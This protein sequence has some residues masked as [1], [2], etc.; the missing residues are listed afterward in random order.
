[1]LGLKA[2]TPGLEALFILVFADIVTFTEK[3]ARL[4]FPQFHEPCD[5]TSFEDGETDPEKAVFPRSH[6]T[7]RHSGNLS[8]YL[9]KSKPRS[10]PILVSKSKCSEAGQPTAVCPAP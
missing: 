10:A 7:Q 6:F 3:D 4:S 1:V 8:F 9:P 5:I 2:T